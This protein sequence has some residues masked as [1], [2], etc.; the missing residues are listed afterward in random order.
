MVIWL[1]WPWTKLP[2]AGVLV[3][4]EVGPRP[5]TQAL[6]TG[7]LPTGLYS[8]HTPEEDPTTPCAH[9][10]LLQERE[11]AEGNA[12]SG[13][14]L[15]DL[16]H[17]LLVLPHLFLDQHLYA[18]VMK[19]H[20]EGDSDTVPGMAGQGT[21]HPGRCWLEMAPWPRQRAIRRPGRTRAMAVA[22][23]LTP[24]DWLCGLGRLTPP[25]SLSFHLSTPPCLKEE[26]CGGLE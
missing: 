12:L 16:L 14:Q 5:D 10:V 4:R 19:A 8:N 6:L 18:P 15:A 1:N 13:L 25:L 9:S 17:L 11:P 20:G 23:I 2:V 21:W 26:V 7:P 24:A 22:A 3:V